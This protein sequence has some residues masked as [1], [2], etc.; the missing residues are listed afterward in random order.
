MRTS[1]LTRISAGILLLVLSGIA[2]A[3]PKRP[4]AKLHSHASVKH[5]SHKKAAHGSIH[6]EPPAVLMPAER[7]TQIQSAL[8]KRG[9]LTGEPTGTWD[10][11]TV[12]AMQKL[13][14]DNG[15]QSKVTPDS[16]ALIKLGLG[17]ETSA[18]AVEQG[19]SIAQTQPR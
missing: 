16:R 10:S 15:W 12:A 5:T 8:I 11:Q 3:G 14:E 1:N 7:A 19:S 18:P 6:H 2:T 9:Y 4:P 13:Q 17:P